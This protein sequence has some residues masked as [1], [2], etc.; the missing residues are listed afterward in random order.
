MED[1]TSF[2]ENAVKKARGLAEYSGEMS[3]ADDSGLE[4]DALGGRPGIFSSRYAGKNADDG[5]NIRKLLQDMNGVPSEMRG[6]AFRCTLVLYGPDGIYEAFEG[7][8]RGTIA[9]EPR[10]D[11]GFGYDPL[12]FIP[13]YR[14]TVAE[15][16]P[17]LKNRIS[18]RGQALR[19]LKKHFRS[20][21]QS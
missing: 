16:P 1:G 5:E 11:Q 4:V 18:H 2:L 19:A 14:M 20:L 17:D 13:E 8:L 12:F 9:C 15:M 21:L 10:G 6:A 7:S 3:L